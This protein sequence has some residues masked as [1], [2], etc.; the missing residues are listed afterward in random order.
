MQD[1]LESTLSSKDTKLNPCDPY[2]LHCV[3]T[4]GI[5]AVFDNAIMSIR[6][7]IRILELVGM[8]HN[9]NLMEELIAQWRTVRTL[10]RQNLIILDSMIWHDVPSTPRKSC[11]W[12]P[13]RWKG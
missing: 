12:Q 7:Q 2:T 8:I 10:W 9:E 5:L 6:D 3:V 1:R 4:E 13:I 11:T